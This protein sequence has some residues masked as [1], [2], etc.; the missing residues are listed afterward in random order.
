METAAKADQPVL[1]TYILDQFTSLGQGSHIPWPCL[2]MAAIIGSIPTG[3]VF[4]NKDPK[5]F[6]TTE[7][8]APHGTKGAGSQ[9]RI[10]IRHDRFAYADYILAHGADINAGFPEHSPVRAAVRAA[11]EDGEDLKFSLHLH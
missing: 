6:E 5:C 1:L 7:P 8:A 11:V 4:Y 10:A 9:I 3:K 2:R